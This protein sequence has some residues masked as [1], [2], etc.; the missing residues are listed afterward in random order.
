MTESKSFL[1]PDLDYSQLE[2]DLEAYRLGRRDVDE[3]SAGI[4]S[5]R[6][7]CQEPSTYYMNKQGNFVRE[8][9]QERAA[10]NRW[11]RQYRAGGL[12]TF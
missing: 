9:P 11:A 7:S 8:A 2:P 10:I 5:G 12:D 4:S 3:N 1:F 6:I